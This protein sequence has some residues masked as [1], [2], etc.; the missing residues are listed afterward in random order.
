MEKGKKNKI[1][2]SDLILIFNYTV[3]Y[4]KTRSDAWPSATQSE[5]S[6]WSLVVGREGL[7]FSG[8]FV[9][10][11]N[12]HSPKWHWKCWLRATILA[13]VWYPSWYMW[14]GIPPRRL[15]YVIFSWLFL[16]WN[17]SWESSSVTTGQPS[18]RIRAT[19]W[20]SSSLPFVIVTQKQYLTN[21]LFLTSCVW[22][23]SAF[24]IITHKHRWN[25]WSWCSS[26]SLSL[27]C[28]C[29]Q[30]ESQS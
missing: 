17:N 22:S 19:R 7:H 18:T 12:S 10:I 20:L 26:I 2:F 27:H 21:T 30:F 11:I 1:N 14:R 23:R 13:R 3:Y 24:L 4:F 28:E 9:Q 8:V 5:Q 16:P 25:C 29:T 15:C 6:S